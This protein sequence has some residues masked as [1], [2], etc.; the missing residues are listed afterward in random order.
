MSTTGDAA[1][2]DRL[3]WVDVARGIG[4]FL[5]VVGHA[6]RGLLAT[7]I[8]VRTPVEQAVDDWIYAFHMPLFFLLSGL[9]LARTVALPWGRFVR[10]RLA[11]IA[12]PYLVWSY[13]S[14][15]MK[16][17]VAS[18]VN[19]AP[20]PRAF[21]TI[22]Y[23]PIEQFW[24]L[25]VLFLLS[26]GFGILLKLRVPA[27]GMLIL[28]VAVNPAVSP[29]PR[30]GWL[31]LDL[32][33]LHAAAFSVGIVL[34]ATSLPGRIGRLGWPA[35]LLLGAAGMAVPTL[36]VASGQQAEP[37]ISQVSGLA[38]SLGVIAFS[39]L[40]A[41]AGWLGRLLEKWGRLS[42][43]I[44]VAHTIFS[45]ALRILLAK[46][47]GVTDW[48]VHLVSGVF[49]GLY[50]PIVLAMGARR[51]GAW[52]LFSLRRPKEARSTNTPQEVTAVA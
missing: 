25:Y 12:Y 6:M 40:L 36:A 7:G 49:V 17:A 14:L 46:A 45:A 18:R 31:P 5:V 19:V 35:A 32:A 42:L 20:D 48:N 39:S 30:F 24:F 27:W 52:W 10:G 15:A 28:A 23:Q 8:G 4:I 29:L 51:F 44:Y 50:G 9:F 43:E 2:P 26:L 11:T 22:L 34:G 3:E 37:W 47:L 38:G 21:A 16:L 41:R 1:P 33:K 13:I